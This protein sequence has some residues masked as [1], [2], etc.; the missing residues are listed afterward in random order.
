MKRGES[1]RSTVSLRELRSRSV[2]RGCGVHVLLLEDS[3]WK[4]ELK[5]Y[6]LGFTNCSFSLDHRQSSIL[7]PRPQPC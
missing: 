5:D 7:G 3:D 2:T 1:E 6:D 4:I